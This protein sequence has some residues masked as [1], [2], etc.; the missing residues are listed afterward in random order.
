MAIFEQDFVE[1]YTKESLVREL[2]RVAQ[3]VP[4]PLTGELFAK[5]G[6]VHPSTVRRRFGTWQ[7]ALMEAGLGDRWSGKPSKPLGS[8]HKRA[9]YIRQMRFAARA[10]DSR[11]LSQ[12]QFSAQYKCPH[13]RTIAKFF[14]SW[15]AALTAAGLKGSTWNKGGY[16][17][18][19]CLE[20]LELLWE[21]LERQPT[22]A[23]LQRPPSRIGPKAYERHWGS[24]SQ[25]AQA[26]IAWARARSQRAGRGA[27]Q[28][29]SLRQASTTRG[30]TDEELVAEL[31]RISRIT[32]RKTVTH[33]DI[34]THGSVDSR[35][36]K[37]RLGNGSWQKALSRAGLELSIHGRRH[38]DEE[39]HENLMRVWET[40]GA[41]PKYSQMK[42]ASSNITPEAYVAKFGS[43]R[44]ALMA[45]LAWVRSDGPGESAARR[46]RLARD[47]AKTMNSSVNTIPMRVRDPRRTVSLKLRFQV[48]KRDNFKCVICGR[49]PATSPDVQLVVDHKQPHATGGRTLLSN[50]QTLCKECNLGKGIL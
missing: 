14:G 36:V 27:G 11:T 43:W 1:S 10:C 9:A 39:Y 30:L 33:E 42:G 7:A 20:N 41:R 31:R 4:G 13:P 6:R 28:R 26:F 22:Y 2:Q 16:S 19:A 40:I 46:T 17:K 15:C 37:A 29:Y 21:K 50:L 48:F 38:S 35:T 12:T 24:Y 3:L 25:A 5:H 44:K 8:K 45:F 49:S 23:D 47:S 32:G 18:E 34:H